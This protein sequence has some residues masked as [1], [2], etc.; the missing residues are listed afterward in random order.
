MTARRRS[1]RVHPAVAVAGLL[2]ALVV[3]DVAAWALAHAAVLVV[4]G[5]LVLGAVLVRRRNSGLNSPPNSG[6][7]SGLNDQLRAEAADLRRQVEQLERQA[8]ET[9]AL[10]N[11]LEDAAGRPVE[12]IISTYRHL[13]RQYGPAAVGRGKAS[14]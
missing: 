11:D 4:L 13:Q 3:L 8:G 9:D 2:A 14:P 7:N 10:L 6:L 5:G 12:A 1:R